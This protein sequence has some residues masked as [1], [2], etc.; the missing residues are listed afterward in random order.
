MEP[1]NE[2]PFKRDIEVA[3]V[4]GFGFRVT[5][6]DSSMSYIEDQKMWPGG[7]EV[8]CKGEP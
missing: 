8:V 2:G 6:Y 7:G 5:I 1:R 3:R 4:W